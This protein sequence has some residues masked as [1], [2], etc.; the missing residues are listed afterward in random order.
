M[1]PGTFVSFSKFHLNTSKSPNVK[2]VYFVEG[3]NFRVEWHLKFG[4][5][6]REKCKSTLLGTIH[7]RPE[8]CQLGMPIVHNWWRKRPY[9]LYKSCRAMQDLQLWYRNLGPLLLEK[10]EKNSINGGQSELFLP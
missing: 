6:M 9:A 2:V 3:H 1:S 7:W 5:E 8:N 10:I 4:V